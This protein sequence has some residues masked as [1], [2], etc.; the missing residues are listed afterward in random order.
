M[1]YVPSYS[2]DQC[3]IVTNSDTIRVYDTIPTHNSTVNYTEYYLEHDYISFNGSQTFNQYST[4]PTCRNDITTDWYYRV[5]L[6][7]ILIIFV[8]LFIII[9]YVPYKIMRRFF[10]RW[11]MI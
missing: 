8:I 3:A 1:V 10:G 5:D 7:Q 4:L 6:P 2:N 9:Y 11:L